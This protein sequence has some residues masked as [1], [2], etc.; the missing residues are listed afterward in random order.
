VGMGML[1]T[2]IDTQ[3]PT[4]TCSK[5]LQDILKNTLTQHIIESTDHNH[6]VVEICSC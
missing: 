5:W 4:S 3:M 1:A 6:K 2:A